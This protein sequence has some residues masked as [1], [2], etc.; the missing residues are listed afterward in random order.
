M[1]KVR[2][3]TILFCVTGGI[4]IYKA[5]GLASKLT[6]AGAAVDVVMTPS[7]LE[8]VQPLLFSS[9]THR[10]VYCNPWQPDRKPEH[11]ALAERPDVIVVAPA[12]A[13]TIAKLANGIA[14][15]LL[16]SA[17]LASVK[18][19]LLAPA[20]N[21]AMWQ[22]PSTSR[23][24]KQLVADGYQF[25]GPAAGNL[26]CGDTGIGRMAEPETIAAAIVELLEKEAARTTC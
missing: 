26:A 1:E 4:A 21:T 16:L 13:N 12:T 7:A 11:I 3:K 2:G 22:A 8:F 9:L 15:N 17:L 14:D 25:V 19:V 6:Q 5:V 24:V 18:P 23:N 20:M 10:Q